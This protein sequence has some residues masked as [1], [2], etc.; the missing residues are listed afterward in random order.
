MDVRCL[1]I[2]RRSREAEMDNNDEL[3]AEGTTASSV[4][5]ALSRE[6]PGPAVPGFQNC[7]DM[8]VSGQTRRPNEAGVHAGT[9][10]LKLT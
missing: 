2:G 8:V 3:G 1:K 6:L 7:S 9:R 10:Q 5:V 4:S